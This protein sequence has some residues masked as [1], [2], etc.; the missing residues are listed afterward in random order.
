[1]NSVKAALVGLAVGLSIVGIGYCL[2]PYGAEEYLARWFQVSSKGHWETVVLNATSRKGSLSKLF[3]DPEIPGLQGLIIEGRSESGKPGKSVVAWGIGEH[4][5]VGSVYGPD[6]TDVTAEAVKKTGAQNPLAILAEQKPSRREI[7]QL[8]PQQAYEA[9]LQLTGY[10]QGPGTGDRVVI[11]F[12]SPGCVYCR[13]LKSYLEANEK[14]FTTTISVRWVPVGIRSSDMTSAVQQLEGRADLVE[15]NSALLNKITG[16]YAAVPYVIW[17]TPS[18]EVR[19]SRG[20][21]QEPLW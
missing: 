16:G 6:G 13:R 3:D 9:A 14:E 2:G 1:M 17:K 8:E 20:V 7:S 18:G 21:P 11:V 15:E 5:I 4:I 12:S 10:I 19:C